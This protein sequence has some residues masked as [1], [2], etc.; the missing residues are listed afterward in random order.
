MPDEDRKNPDELQ[1]LL[2]FDQ[3]EQQEEKPQQS[4][5]DLVRLF[6]MDAVHG[7]VFSVA[8]NQNK[9]KNK[10]KCYGKNQTSG[11]KHVANIQVIKDPI[12]SSHRKLRYLQL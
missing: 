12:Y 6:E 9:Y 8:P 10:K 11:T 7:T 4:Q 5:K 3:K 2:Y 1:I